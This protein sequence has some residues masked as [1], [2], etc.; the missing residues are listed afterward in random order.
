MPKVFDEDVQVLNPRLRAPED[1]FDLQRPEICPFRHLVALNAFGVEGETPGL[2][3]VR[4]YPCDVHFLEIRVGTRSTMATRVCFYRKQR[5]LHAPTT[6]DVDQCNLTR[7]HQVEPFT[8]DVLQVRIA[9]GR[10]RGRRSRRRRWRRRW[11]LSRRRRR[12]ER[13]G[14]GRTG[15]RAACR[16]ARRTGRRG[17][18]RA[19]RRGRRGCCSRTLEHQRRSGALVEGFARPKTTAPRPH[20]FC[21]QRKR[22]GVLTGEFRLW[23]GACER[24]PDWAWVCLIIANLLL[25]AR[26]VGPNSGAFRPRVLHREDGHLWKGTSSIVSR[27]QQERCILSI[28]RNA[29]LQERVSSAAPAVGVALVDQNL[30]GTIIR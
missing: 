4:P 21:N 24:L 16:A 17:R 7:R 29:E 15:G 18:G 9:S 8:V 5:V 13:R 20:P 22:D 30:L 25:P 27:P 6:W 3:L 14:R 26:V 12:V 1:D 11:R 10:R 28:A 19:A 23:N 2:Q